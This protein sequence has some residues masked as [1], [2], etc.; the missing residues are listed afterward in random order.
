MEDAHYSETDRQKDSETERTQLASALVMAQKVYGPVQ[1][2]RSSFCVFCLAAILRVTH[3][4][5]RT[6]GQNN[7]RKTINKT[8]LLA[9]FKHLTSVDAG[10]SEIS[11]H[12]FYFLFLCLFHFIET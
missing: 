4:T 1:Y 2:T 11:H 9:F 12:F 7:Q 3:R 10:V 6:G 5:F 8:I